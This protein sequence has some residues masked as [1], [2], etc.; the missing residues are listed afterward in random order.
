MTGDIVARAK[1]ALEGNYGPA[2]A[3][4][5]ELVKALEQERLHVGYL[6]ASVAQLA[7]DKANALQLW[8]QAQDERDDARVEVGLAHARLGDLIARMERANSDLQGLGAEAAT[9]SDAEAERLYGK[10]SGVRLAL[11][12]VRE[13]RNA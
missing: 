4:V 1:A 11:S 10:A 9:R 13:A 8:G 12:Y 7:T 6:T 5:R 3:L 2:A